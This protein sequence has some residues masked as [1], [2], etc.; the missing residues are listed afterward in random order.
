MMMIDYVNTK[1][2]Q[3]NNAGNATLPRSPFFYFSSVWTVP[4]IHT[5]EVSP[6]I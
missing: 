4:P 6:V 5:Q 2:S 1:R 3:L